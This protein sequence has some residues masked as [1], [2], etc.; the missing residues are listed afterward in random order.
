MPARVPEDLDRILHDLRGPLNAATMHVELLK[1]VV[2]VGSPG[3]DSV[4]ALQYEL[5]RLGEMI[6]TAIGIAAVE[7][8]DL[9][10]VDLRAVVEQALRRHELAG[11]EIEDAAWPRV[12]GDPRLLAQAVEQLALNAVEATAAH[13]PG[14]AVPRVRPARAGQGHVAIV[15]RDF[16][17]GLRS[18]NP[19]VL[20]RLFGS[21]KPGHRGVGLLVA[22]RIARL[23]GGSLRFAS[24]GVGAEVS[25]L[26]PATA[27]P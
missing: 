21:T 11:V 27:Q 14:T 22:E 18:T 9:T 17:P 1:R 7:R 26:L 12:V 6:T 4:K 3:A 15:V 16:G 20:I 2:G 25:L 19:K 24:P 13:G 5:E 23:H 10:S 8:G